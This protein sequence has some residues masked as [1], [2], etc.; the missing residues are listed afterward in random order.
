MLSNIKNMPM[1]H[2]VR[3]PWVT[4]A[5]FLTAVGSFT[6][7]IAASNAAMTSAAIESLVPI[8]NL[9]SGDGFT[10]LGEPQLLWPP[11]YGLLA[12]PVYLIT[13]NMELAATG[14]SIAGYFVAV[15]AAFYAGKTITNSDS[16]GLLAGI[17]VAST[18]LVLQ[19]TGL[20]LI[21]DM[22]FAAIYLCCF[23]LTAQWIFHGPSLR[24]A[25]FLGFLAGTAYLCRPEG[26]AIALVVPIFMVMMIGRY[27][28][29]L[30]IQRKQGRFLPVAVFY[31]TFL[32]LAVPYVVFL[33][34]HTDSWMI[35]GKTNFNLHAG[36]KVVHGRAHIDSL[37]GV[38]S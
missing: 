23:A 17:T 2:V 36:E 21:V 19:A 34:H 33:H 10:L 5:I 22:A 28:D 26:A 1:E 25:A 16:S 31:I 20:L 29:Q 15:I 7:V 38:E 3:I 4:A 32:I 27:K 30:G 18:P 6:V 35:S 13:G 14:V 11:G 9:L 12:T 8:V 24:T 37:W